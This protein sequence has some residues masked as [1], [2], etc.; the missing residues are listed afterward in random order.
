LMEF[1]AIE[2]VIIPQMIRG[3]SRQEASQRAAHPAGRRADRKSRP[4]HLR[5]R[6]L[7]AHPA[8]AS[9]GSG[10]RRRHPQHGHRGAHGPARHA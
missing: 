10:G 9:L 3:L 2:N 7:R 5:A 1:S 8:G 4:T 6:L